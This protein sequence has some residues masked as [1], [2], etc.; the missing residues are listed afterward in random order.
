MWTIRISKKV[1]A[2]VIAIAAICVGLFIGFKQD[3]LKVV[4]AE[5]SRTT[6]FTKAERNVL[7]VIFEFDESY[8]DQSEEIK[9]NCKVI[10]DYTDLGYGVYDIKLLFNIKKDTYEAHM[11]YD[12]EEDEELVSYGIIDGE[13]IDID[14]WNEIIESR[15]PEID[16]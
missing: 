4:H 10:S 6:G 15:Y 12:G 16:W 1:V 11:I 5:E 8:E 7:K 2:M 3:T 14:E 13:R 9:E